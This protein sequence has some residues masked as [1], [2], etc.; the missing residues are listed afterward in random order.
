MTILHNFI[1]RTLDGRDI[2]AAQWAGHPVL[3]VN[4]ASECGLTPQYQGLQTLYDTHPGL[5]VLGVP[6]NQ[7]G[8]QEPGSEA[9]IQQF[10][11]QEYGISFP[12]LA[13]TE[14]N[15]SNRHPLYEWL[16]GEASPFAGDIEW[17]FA[18]FL[19]DAQGHR[20]ARFHPQITPEDPSLRQAI[21]QALSEQPA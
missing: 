13:K 12:M 5:I 17:N 9:Q 7:F 16:A 18:K 6:C 10:C 1:L 8:G 14:V 11:T 4:V 19:I 2:S 15:G 21:A 3:I 20:R